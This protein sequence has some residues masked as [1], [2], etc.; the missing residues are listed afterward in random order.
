MGARDSLRAVF[1]SALHV[2]RHVLHCRAI[3]LS[4]RSGI[5]ELGEANHGGNNRRWNLL[6]ASSAA[7]CVWPTANR[8]MARRGFRL[9][10]RHGRAAQ[11]ASIVARSPHLNSIFFVCGF[12]LAAFFFWL[13]REPDFSSL[14]DC[15]ET[16]NQKLP[17]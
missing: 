15:S 4:E 17:L 13:F 2:D 14:P 16:N 7:V 5:I 8:W 11:S 1:H 6:P 9:V 12:V 10:S 3:S